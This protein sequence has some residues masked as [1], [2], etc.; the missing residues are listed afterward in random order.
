MIFK[1][2]QEEGKNDVINILG[3]YTNLNKSFCIQYLTLS[4]IITLHV[5][6]FYSS[7]FL[8]SPPI[9]TYDLCM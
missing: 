8:Y 4:L 3:C 7:P 5:S 6:R 1:M 2:D 9:W